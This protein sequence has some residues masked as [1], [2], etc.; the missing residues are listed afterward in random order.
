MDQS[1]S[2][3]VLFV[4]ILFYKQGGGMEVFQI[5]SDLHF[6]KTILA[7][8]EGD[9]GSRWGGGWRRVCRRDM[10]AERLAEG[11]GKS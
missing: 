6:K 1:Q 4:W 7:S 9:L 3:R 8:V 10:E 2:Q 11:S 5:R